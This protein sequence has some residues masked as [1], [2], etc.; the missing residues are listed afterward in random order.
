MSAGRAN[1]KTGL[2]LFCGVSI[3][4]IVF[5]FV[6]DWEETNRFNEFRFKAYDHAAAIQLE[7]AHIAKA[8]GDVRF[9][10][11]HDINVNHNNPLNADDFMSMAEQLIIHDPSLQSIAWAI[12]ENSAAQGA[13]DNPIRLQ[14]IYVKNGMH[15]DENTSDIMLGDDYYNHISVLPTIGPQQLLRVFLHD[16]DDD[17]DGELNFIGPV[18]NRMQTG[19]SLG[20]KHIGSLIV[21]WDIQGLIEHAIAKMPVAAQDIRVFI[22]QQDGSRKSVYQHFSRSRTAHE[23]QIK[24]GLF[25]HVAFEFSGL[26]WQLEFEAAPEFLR[27]HPIVLAWQSLILCLLVTFFFAWYSRFSRAQKAVVE[28]QVVDRTEELS[29]SRNE[30]YRI[31][32][33]LQDTY[34]QADIEGVIQVVSASIQDLSGYSMDET[35]GTRLTD[36]YANSDGWA[37]FM[38]ALAAAD[39]G[40]IYHYEIEGVHKN[41]HRTWISTN[42]QLCYDEKGQVTGVEGTWRDITEKKQQEREEEKMQHQLEHTQRLESLGVLAGGIA[43]DFNNILASVMG[44]ASLAEHKLPE[45]PQ[46]AKMHL[47]KITDAADKAAALCQQMLAYAGKGRFNVQPFNL[48]VLVDEISKLFTVSISPTVRLTCDLQRDLPCIEADKA[49]VQQVIMNCITNANEAIEEKGGEVT[50][51]TGVMYVDVAYFSH[52]IG[53]DH[54]ATGDHVFIRISD[55]GCGMDGKTVKQVFE[56]FFT[57][58]FIGRG[59]GMSAALGIIRSHGGAIRCESEVGKGTIFTVLFPAAA[60]TSTVPDTEPE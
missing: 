47:K 12:A 7:F 23:M 11:E 29:K 14:V 35:R 22:Q 15:S 6:K 45:R 5:L 18:A 21:E 9:L 58:K 59:L 52:C 32:D 30:I 31:I 49:Q 57:T 54:H 36:Y 51:A 56:P 1:L 33:H 38:Q 53:T 17:D 4:L 42:S 55:T 40:K 37:D 34:Y 46:D 3:A 25:D 50:V 41:G 27:E 8:V 43:H 39:G 13:D 19:D 28:Q 48:S 44:N 2:T 16:D 26:H 10:I 60:A 24:T 20:G